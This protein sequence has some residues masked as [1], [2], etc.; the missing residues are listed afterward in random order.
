MFFNEILINQLIKGSKSIKICT[1]RWRPK[2]K[3]NL[4]EVTYCNHRLSL[5]VDSQ[6]AGCVSNFPYIYWKQV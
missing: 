3:I 2:N 5:V 6:Q 1:L 4:L